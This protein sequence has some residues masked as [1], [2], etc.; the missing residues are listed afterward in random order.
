[1]SA[2]QIYRR[3]N[4]R[5]GLA[6]ENFYSHLL[7][8]PG[9]L[10]DFEIPSGLHLSLTSCPSVHFAN[11][12]RLTLFPTIGG[13]L[14]F[15]YSTGPLAGYRGT[16]RSELSDV[17][18]GYQQVDELKTPEEAHQWEVW[19]GGRRVDVRD[20]LLF[21]RLHLPESRLEAVL[22]RRMSPTRQL[23]LTALSD[24]HLPGRGTVFAQL[25]HDFGKWTTEYIYNT[26]DALLGARV[27]RNLGSDP[28]DLRSTRFP[29][30]L[31]PQADADPAEAAAGELIGD[32]LPPSAERDM[33][34]SSYGRFS[35]GMEVYYGALQ[36]SGGLSLGMRFATLPRYHGLPTTATFVV[37]PIVGHLSTTYTLARPKI[38]TLASRLDFNIFSYESDLTLGLE[39]AQYGRRSAVVSSPRLLGEAEEEAVGM[40]I[41]GGAD[42]HDDTMAATNET[43][44]PLDA[45][46]TSTPTAPE[47][48]HQIGLVK[49]SIHTA[50]GLGRVCWQ[51]KAG[52]LLVRLGASFD[53][54]QR[55]LG[56]VGCEVAYAAD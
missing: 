29:R 24:P 7:R 45:H 39:F 15:L 47:T 3:W 54:L 34:L 4:T 53:M 40:C 49:L 16:V 31:P 13:S 27:M 48:D 19:H 52:P 32:N 56:R 28:F 37:N 1:M 6:Q 17:V 9:V 30:I 5:S 20:T 36:K 8:T 43:E 23:V 41:G 55:K 10:L 44:V 22:A 2:E 46:T 12:H 26:E 25:Q 51:G 21:G 11:S 18:E 35:A 50:T 33:P 38:A 42:L 14:G